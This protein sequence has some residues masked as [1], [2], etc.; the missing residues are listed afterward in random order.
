MDKLESADSEECGEA[1]QAIAERL[2]T[3]SYESEWEYPPD[4]SGSEPT[5]EFVEGY[6]LGQFIAAESALDVLR[7]DYKLFDNDDFV[8]VWVDTK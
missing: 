7:Y 2:N 4:D 5:E 6:R 1:L 8:A 3:L